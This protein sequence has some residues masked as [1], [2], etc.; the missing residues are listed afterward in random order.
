[1]LN[2]I[3]AGGLALALALAFGTRAGAEDLLGEEFE[4]FTGIPSAAAEPLEEAEL[5]GLRGRYLKVFFSVELAGVFESAG[6]LDAR[7]DV[8]VGFQPVQGGEAQT[9]SLSFPN[10]GAP[11]GT[12]GPAA[13]PGTTEAT[14]TDPVTGEAFRVAAIVDNG[15][16]NNSNVVAQISQIPGNGNVVQQALVIRL[17]VIDVQESDLPSVEGRLNSLF[18]F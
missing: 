12:A 3:A 14:V 1:M 4:A 15:S 17:A 5:D 11:P 2:P 8:N 16:F 10:S 13:L 9:G 18:G 6:V 7:L